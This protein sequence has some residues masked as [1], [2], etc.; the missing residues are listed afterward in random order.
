MSLK[1]AFQVTGSAA[2]IG[3][4][5]FLDHEVSKE[6]SPLVDI[7]LEL[8]AVVYVK[9]NI[10]QTMMV[11]SSPRPEVEKTFGLIRYR[12]PI[13]RTISLDAL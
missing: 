7:L 4:V 1:D 8:G 5:S 12:R 3:F 11:S 9:T 2:T 10:P 6:N 13:R